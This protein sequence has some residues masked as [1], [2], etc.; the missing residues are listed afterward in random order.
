MAGG[1]G[2]LPE[3]LRRGFLGYYRVLVNMGYVLSQENSPQP[4]TSH[5]PTFKHSC[6]RYVDECSPTV[7]YANL[8]F[9]ENW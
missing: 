9:R 3:D 5:L 8:I 4:I 1:G 2:V 7:I 6:P